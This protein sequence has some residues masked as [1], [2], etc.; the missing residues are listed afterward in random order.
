MQARAPS[1]IGHEWTVELASPLMIQ[2]VTR[3]P[4]FDLT[5]ETLQLDNHPITQLWTSVWFATL[6]Y[7]EV[8]AHLQIANLT[9]PASCPAICPRARMPVL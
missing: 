9:C 4:C 5:K 7:H 2:H 3:H 1:H 6:R 8:F